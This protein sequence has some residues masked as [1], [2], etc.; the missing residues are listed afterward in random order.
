MLIKS[1]RNLIAELAE[2]FTYAWEQ[3]VVIVDSDG[4]ELQK[5]SA[6][7]IIRMLNEHMDEHIATIEAINRS[8]A[9]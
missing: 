6:G 8:Q 1:N 5:V 9:I 7:Q 4:K 3:Y 2:H